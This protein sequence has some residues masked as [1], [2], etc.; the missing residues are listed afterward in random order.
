MLLLF[1]TVNSPVWQHLFV[2][3]SATVIPRR[4]PA[5]HPVRDEVLVMSPFLGYS[6]VATQ[7]LSPRRSTGS[8]VLQESWLGSHRR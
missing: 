2:E 5:D 7:P 3:I 6:M 1:L 4:L 8:T